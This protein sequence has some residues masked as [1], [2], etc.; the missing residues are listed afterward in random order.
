M[1]PKERAF[2]ALLPQKPTQ[3][4]IVG[5]VPVSGTEFYKMRNRLNRKIKMYGYKVV[6]IGKASLGWHYELLR[7]L[8]K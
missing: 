4:Q 1:T 3:A 8:D 2:M 5:G 6:T 7:V